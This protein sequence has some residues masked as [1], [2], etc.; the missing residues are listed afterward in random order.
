MLMSNFSLIVHIRLG[1]CSGVVENDRR[2]G[3]DKLSVSRRLEVQISSSPRHPADNHPLP[4]HKIR[5]A[6]GV[7]MHA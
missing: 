3:V 5:L 2:K 4:P 7:G 1:M 6:P